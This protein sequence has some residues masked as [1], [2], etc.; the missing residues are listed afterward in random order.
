LLA[1]TL[2]HGNPDRNHKLRN[3]VSTERYIPHMQVLLECC[4]ISMETSRI[5]QTYEANFIQGPLKKNQ[6]KL[7]FNFT[8]HYI[9]DVLSLNNSRF[10]NSPYAGAAGMLLHINGNFTMGK[11]KSSL[12]S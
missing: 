5:K 12:L 11:L 3:I 1:A 6:K 8:F 9:D 2:Y 7:A 4:Y 10:G